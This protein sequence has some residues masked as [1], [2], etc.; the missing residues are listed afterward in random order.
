MRIKLVLEMNERRN[1]L[2]S[3]AGKFL[4]QARLDNR[5]KQASI[6]F[7]QNQTNTQEFD[8]AMSITGRD[9]LDPI[10]V[11]APTGLLNNS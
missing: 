11:P 8:F 6:V 3:L 1:V 5:T 2:L 9:G 7:A 10:T 4:A